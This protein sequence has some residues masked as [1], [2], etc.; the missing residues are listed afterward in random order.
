MAESLQEQLATPLVLLNHPDAEHLVPTL[1]IHV[2]DKNAAETLK[3]AKDAAAS[4]IPVDADAVAETCGLPVIP[5]PEGAPPRRMIPLDVT[6]PTD[7]EPELAPIPGPGTAGGAKLENEKT[8]AAQPHVM[9][10]V[11]GAKPPPKET[12]T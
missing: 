2:D 10:G 8:K 9:P 11:P 3:L 5:L 1:T 12:E 4:N 7:L 6:L